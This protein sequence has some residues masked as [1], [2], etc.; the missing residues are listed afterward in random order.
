MKLSDV[1]QRKPKV[2][3]RKHSD[4]CGCRKCLG[5]DVIDSEM[6][7]L[8][9]DMRGTK[10]RDEWMRERE[11]VKT[12]VRDVTNQNVLRIADKKTKE[13][14]AKKQSQAEVTSRANKFLRALGVMK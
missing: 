4:G 6:R 5:M 10:A 13:I 9:R 7:E 2:I 11:K 14:M 3:I 12:T 1:L 8:R